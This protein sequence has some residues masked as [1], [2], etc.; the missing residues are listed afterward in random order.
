[1]TLANVAK[2]ILLR[3]VSSIILF[4]VLFSP[5][6]FAE[7]EHT[8]HGI[9]YYLKYYLPLIFI[10]ACVSALVRKSL[11][12]HPYVNLITEPFVILLICIF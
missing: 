1:M 12:N 7:R 10:C 6:F 11:T 3:T 8:E 4:F 9:G 2:S 5:I